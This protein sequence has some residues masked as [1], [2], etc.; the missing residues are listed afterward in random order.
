MSSSAARVRNLTR[1]AL[2][3]AEPTHTLTRRVAVGPN[4]G[5]YEIVFDAP[6]PGP[7]LTFFVTGEPTP[8]LVGT[9]KV[10]AWGMWQSAII[11]ALPLP[12]DNGSANE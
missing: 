3:S 4:A 5:E 8:A 9:Y 12:G 7:S 2:L 1:S 11:K 10:L 6:L